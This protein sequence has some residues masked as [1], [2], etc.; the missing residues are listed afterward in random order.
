MTA[1]VRFVQGGLIIAVASVASCRTTSS[2]ATTKT[3]V[4]RHDAVSRVTPSASDQDASGDA[5]APTSSQ[6]VTPVVPM[7][8]SSSDS[9][10]RPVT[11]IPSNTARSTAT[12]VGPMT[13]GG[14]NILPRAV[15]AEEPPVLAGAP[16][17]P[18]IPALRLE[19]YLSALPKVAYKGLAAIFSD[20]AT[21]WY[22]HE[23]VL[24]AYQD[25][26][27]DGVNF[28]IGPRLNSI[29]RSLIVPE[30]KKFFLDSGAAWSFPFTKTAG[31][32]HSDNI[33][34]VNFVHLPVVDG[35][36]LPI[37]YRVD[38]GLAKLSGLNLSRWEWIY[39]RGTTIG[40]LIFVKA[41]DGGLLPVEVR[42]RVRQST[43]WAANA[44]RPFPTA[45][46]FV[47]ALKAIRPQ[48]AGDKRLSA[49][50]DQVNNGAPLKSLSLESKAFPGT[51][52]QDGYIDILPDI[53]DEALVAQ[54][55][56]NTPFVSAYGAVWRRVGATQT[57]AAS[58]QM[59]TSIVPRNYE[60][61]VIEVRDQSCSRCHQDAGRMLG[62]F[63]QATTLY[64][65]LWG[66]D[67]IFS[68]HPF[69]PDPSL[70]GADLGDKRRVRPELKGLFV[71]YIPSKHHDDRYRWL[72][73]PGNAR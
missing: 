12:P 10:E 73:R 28:P 31:T 23:A 24:P 56:R 40:E 41:V 9:T 58:S 29:G 63:E 36:R 42:T 66:S 6:A 46:R 60:A 71:P 53:G 20:P 38:Q 67:R 68:F 21:I 30:G 33:I 17:V 25:T 55:T 49:V 7:T 37:V 27:G 5:V 4:T 35:I 62:D 43:A 19:R 65:D 72:P 61:G 2:P 26:V 59:G 48:W 13:D 3:T 64:G 16:V 57:F 45:A 11:P 47:E 69:P 18:L 50:V 15:V 39:P 22:D 70:Y 51:F 32:D 54:L 8:P 1:Y 52:K 34:V 44:F 14:T